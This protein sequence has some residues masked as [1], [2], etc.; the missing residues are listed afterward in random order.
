MNSVKR[1]RNYVKLSVFVGIFFLFTVFLFRMNFGVELYG[2]VSVTLLQITVHNVFGDTYITNL[3]LIS[4]MIFFVF[5]LLVFMF[6][7]RK[8]EVDNPLLTEVVIINIALSL[9]LVAGQ[10]VYIYMIPDSINGFVVER[11]IFTEFPITSD[12]IVRAFNV[13]YLLSVGY[14]IYNMYVLLK[15]MPPKVEI[16]DTNEVD[17]ELE[18]EKLLQ[19]FTKNE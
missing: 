16:D 19:Q 1:L 12:N 18:E 9:V 2:G 5:N 3:P 15:T 7:S 11:F 17:I 6:Y 4:F 10:I 14:T 8:S 13:T